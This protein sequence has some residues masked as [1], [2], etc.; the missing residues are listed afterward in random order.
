MTIID[1]AIEAEC[2]R[3]LN[4]FGSA[5]CPV[6]NVSRGWF[7]RTWTGKTPHSGVGGIQGVVHP[8]LPS[9][10]IGCVFTGVG[11]FRSRPKVD[12]IL[13]TTYNNYVI[14]FSTCCYDSSRVT[15]LIFVRHYGGLS[16]AAASQGRGTPTFSSGWSL[17]ELNTT[18]LNP[19]VKYKWNSM[20]N[21]M[22]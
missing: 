7:A 15:I 6:I 10:K 13:A 3:I 5:R 20:N 19:R 22:S 18:P 21:P 12:I 2:G 4:R 11:V 1:L 9:T 17:E 14:R 8:D 16:A